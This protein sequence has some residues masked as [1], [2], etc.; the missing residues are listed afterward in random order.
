MRKGYI[1]LLTIATELIA[2]FIISKLI[3]LNFIDTLFLGGIGLF[4]VVWL[5]SFSMTQQNNV[6]NASMKGI[7]GQKTGGIKVFRFNINPI[8]L[9][10]LIFCIS[11]FIITMIYYSSYFIG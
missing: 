8:T 5:F 11:S 2:L 7:T 4:G 3:T 1:V 10:L 6:F 9:G